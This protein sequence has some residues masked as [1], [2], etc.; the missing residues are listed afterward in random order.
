MRVDPWEFPWA[1]P[2]EFPRGSSRGGSSVGGVQWELTPLESGRIIMLNC[3]L[4]DS[5]SASK[6]KGNAAPMYRCGPSP[7]SSV[8]LSLSAL[9]SLLFLLRPFD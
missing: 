6:L 1:F 7:V 8:N 9:S 5:P 2:W 4:T 3:E